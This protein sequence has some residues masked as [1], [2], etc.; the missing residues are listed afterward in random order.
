MAFGKILLTNNFGEQSENTIQP[1]GSSSGPEFV[2]A[3]GAGLYSGT[4]APNFACE[5]G[6]LYLRTNG[7]SA[8]QVLYVNFDGAALSWAPLTGA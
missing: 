7:A 6:S 3:S 5:P 4:G 8:D 2:F 1:Q